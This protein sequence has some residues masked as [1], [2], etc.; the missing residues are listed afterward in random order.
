VF[1]KWGVLFDE[2]SGMI[3]AGHSPLYFGMS[4]SLN[5]QYQCNYCYVY[6][7][8]I[9]ACEKACTVLK[10]AIEGCDYRWARDWILDLLTHLHTPL[11][12]ASN[13]SATANLHNI[14][15]TTAKTKSSPACNVFNSRFLVTDVYSG[16]SSD[17]SPQILPLKFQYRT[18]CA[19]ST[20]LSQFPLSRT[21][22]LP[23]VLII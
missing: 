10:I 11:G 6:A 16:D 1:L 19:L 9:M 17:S 12:S 4:V 22:S 13:Y 7:P 5:S 20:E 15:M 21:L 18:N 14:K 3:I 2:T 23:G 8:E